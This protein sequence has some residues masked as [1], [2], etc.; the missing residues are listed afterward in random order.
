VERERAELAHRGLVCRELVPELALVPV[1]AVVL[2]QRGEQEQL[3][4]GN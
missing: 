4:V 3:V 1:L 2:V